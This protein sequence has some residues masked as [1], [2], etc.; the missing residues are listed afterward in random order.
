[1]KVCKNCG[2]ETEKVSR[3]GWCPDCAALVARQA[4]FEMQQKDGIYFLRWQVGMEKAKERRRE[5]QSN[6]RGALLPSGR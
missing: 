2:V 3:R 6:V 5:C 4:A 1:M